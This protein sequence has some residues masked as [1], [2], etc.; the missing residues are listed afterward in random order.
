[1]ACGNRL[2][3]K[4]GLRQALYA[5]IMAFQNIFAELVRKR[6]CL[7]K[8][9]E[10]R[11]QPGRQSFVIRVHM[12]DQYKSRPRCVKKKRSRTVSEMSCPLVL[13]QPDIVMFSGSGSG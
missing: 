2:A 1:M 11:E 7:P 5:I 13:F 6:G 8:Q 4:H 9:D 3:V 12:G 10:G